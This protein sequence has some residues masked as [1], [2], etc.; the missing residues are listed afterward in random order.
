MS[1]LAVLLVL[2]IVGFLTWLL[3]QFVPMEPPFK[4]IIVGVIVIL[5]VL[6]LLQNFGVF[7][8]PRMRL[9]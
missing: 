1:I 5:T 7:T 9:W 8:G 4:Q 3:I 2:V 6:W